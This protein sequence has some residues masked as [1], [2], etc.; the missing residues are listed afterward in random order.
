MVQKDLPVLGFFV[1]RGSGPEIV[2]TGVSKTAVSSSQGG[3][4]F[5]LDPFKAYLKIFINLRFE[6]IRILVPYLA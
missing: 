5:G 6:N 3:E 1:L 4:C 2:K